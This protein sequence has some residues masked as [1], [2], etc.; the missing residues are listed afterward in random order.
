MTKFETFTPTQGRAIAH[1]LQL[2][3]ERTDVYLREQADYEASLPEGQ[4]P[5]RE[6][7]SVEQWEEFDRE[8]F[9]EMGTAPD[10]LERTVA[11]LKR[12][13]IET[14]SPANGYRYALEKYWGRLL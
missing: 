10:D 1:F 13:R 6:E 14:D 11:G 4:R 8:L 3:A 7:L 12:N 5:N 9:A 2:E